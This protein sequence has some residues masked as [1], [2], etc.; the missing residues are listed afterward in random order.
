MCKKCKLKF[1]TGGIFMNTLDYAIKME[2]DGEKYY[3]EQADINRGNSLYQVFNMLAIDES[4]HAKIL[5]D[6]SKG[7][8]SQLNSSVQSSVE[9]VFAGLSDFKMDIKTN[10]DQADVYRRALEMEKAS[11]E[12]YKK[13][14]SETNES[15]DIFD[16]L[17]SQEEGHYRVIDELFKIANRPNEWVEAAEFGRREDY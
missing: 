8:F 12:L 17:I 14:K 13:L 5:E 7:I 15:I 2:L 10:P 9:N 11:I 1:I 6:K 16:F 3:R 4:F